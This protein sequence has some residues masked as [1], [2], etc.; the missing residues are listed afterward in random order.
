MDSCTNNNI[1]RRHNALNKTGAGRRNLQFDLINL[2][3]NEVTLT[4]H[5]ESTT[6]SFAHHQRITKH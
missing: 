2:H 6:T 5:K 3:H 4:K 1:E